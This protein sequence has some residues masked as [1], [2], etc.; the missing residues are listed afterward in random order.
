MLKSVIHQ[1]DKLKKKINNQIKYNSKSKDQPFVGH[2]LWKSKNLI[3][4]FYK[5]YKMVL[6]I[7]KIKIMKIIAIKLN[8]K[9]I[10]IKQ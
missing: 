6:F 2:H 10:K 7:K 9:L 4:L 3:I 8:N 5:I 1:L